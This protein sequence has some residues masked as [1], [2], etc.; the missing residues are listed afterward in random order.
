M[1]RTCLLASLLVTACMADDAEVPAPDEAV[2]GTLY[3]NNLELKTE[4][5]GNHSTW[6][7]SPTAYCS[8]YRRLYGMGSSQPSNGS[9]LFRGTLPQGVGL[10]SAAQAAAQEDLAGTSSNWFM[11]AYAI[12][13]DELDGQTMVWQRS[14]YS[15]AATRDVTVT[16]PDNK[17]VIGAGGTINFG[18]GR[19]KI[20]EIRPNEGLTQVSVFASENQ[21]TTSEDWGVTAYAICATKPAGLIRVAASA[22]TAWTTGQQ[23]V[24]T[25]PEEKRLLSVAGGVDASTRTNLRVF[26]MRPSALRSATVRATTKGGAPGVTGNVKAYAICA[27]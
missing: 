24:A 19:V 26:E 22:S 25:C 20:D 5:S 2:A 7:R 6:W 4:N 15:S 9:I 27:D 17:S 13:G 3:I 1:H 8:P 10:P 12:C 21:D 23:V 18:E 14:V 11:T 16:C